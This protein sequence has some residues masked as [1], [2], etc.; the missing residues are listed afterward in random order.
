MVP[1]TGLVI[2]SLDPDK[3]Y[4]AFGTSQMM[5]AIIIA[6]ALDAGAVSLDDVVTMTESAL[7]DTT[8]TFT[9]GLRPGDRISVE[10]L[11]YGMLLP[12][13]NDATFLLTEHVSGGRQAFVDAMNA[14]AAT[15]GLTNTR[16]ASASGLVPSECAGGNFDM[17]ICANYS[18]ARDLAAL[19]EFLM[20]RPLLA[21]IVGTKEHETISWESSSGMPLNRKLC[22]I[23]QL[24]PSGTTCLSAN[25]YEG[26]HG[27]QTG[28]TWTLSGSFV[29]RATREGTTILVV[30][31]DSRA[32]DPSANR[33]TDAI[34]LLDFGFE[35]AP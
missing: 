22:N 16:F 10:D 19:A 32:F 7:E 20:E 30:V 9:M 34:T 3:R 18:T 28:T 31:Q 6:D 12:G 14:K 8:G 24:L 17:P 2:G 21:Q 27:V 11:L 13:T 29:A 15:F 25:E 4:D 35:N 5:S 33:N 26:A 1:E 23:S